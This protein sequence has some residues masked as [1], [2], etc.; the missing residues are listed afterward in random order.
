MPFSFLQFF[1]VVRNA[2]KSV[3]FCHW[4]ETVA[5]GLLIVMLWLYFIKAWAERI[6]S[7]WYPAPMQL[8]LEVCWLEFLE[9]VKYL[10]G[11]VI[12]C[13]SFFFHGSSSPWTALAFILLIICE[14][15]ASSPQRKCDGNTQVL[16]ICLACPLPPPFFNVLHGYS[17]EC[18]ELN[19][20]KFTHNFLELMRRKKDLDSTLQWLSREDGYLNLTESKDIWLTSGVIAYLVFSPEVFFTFS[21]YLGIK[22][23]FSLSKRI[24]KSWNILVWIYYSQFLLRD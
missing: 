17:N 8:V 10:D 20:S 18:C 16:K 7:L 1:L 11:M 15:N 13:F 12:P 19:S 5:P 6:V 22:N 24:I 14:G 21:C 9:G 3:I 23:G 2:L 4:S